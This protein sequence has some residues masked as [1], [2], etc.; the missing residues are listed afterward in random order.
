MQEQVNTY[1]LKRME[2]VLLKSTTHLFFI[3]NSIKQNFIK[4]YKK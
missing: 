1:Y 2:N 4:W 3:Y